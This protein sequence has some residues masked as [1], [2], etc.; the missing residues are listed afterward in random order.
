MVDVAREKEGEEEIKMLVRM[1][2]SG[3]KLD[4][5][6]IFEGGDEDRI[7]IYHDFLNNEDKKGYF[8]LVLESL[9]HKSEFSVCFENDEAKKLIN[10]LSKAQKEVVGR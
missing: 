7:L 8:V 10:A 6:A 3:E 9:S 2:T 4:S 5:P 1:R